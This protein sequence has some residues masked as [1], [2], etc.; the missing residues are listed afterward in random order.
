M[1]LCASPTHT[2]Q[3]Q[4]QSTHICS[5]T[6]QCPAR[7][8]VRTTQVQTLP[9]FYSLSSCYTRHW[10]SSLS[11]ILYAWVRENGKEMGMERERRQKREGRE[12]YK[13]ERDEMEGGMKEGRGNQ[14]SAC[15]SVCLWEDMTKTSNTLPLY[16]VCTKQVP[17]FLLHANNT[18]FPAMHTT[19]QTYIFIL[20][21]S[22]GWN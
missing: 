2:I 13:T 5:V 11:C 20:D 12:R 6:L 19:H 10:L 16:H 21:V 7:D 1:S 3:G 8:P 15:S 17:M 14:S 4:Q 18:S 9:P 22:G